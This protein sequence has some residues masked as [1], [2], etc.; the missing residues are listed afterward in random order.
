MSVALYWFRRDLRVDDNPA[1]AQAIAWAQAHDARL[2]PVVCRED[3]A[4]HSPW[5]PLPRSERQRAWFAQA[6]AALR[7][8]LQALNSDLWEVQD[9]AQA[10]ALARAA[11]VSQVFA[12]RI[13]APD[14]VTQE[15][16]WARAWPDACHFI[17]QSTLLAPQDLPFAP[18]D[19]PR[20]FTAFR[21]AVEAAGQRASL[22][23]VAPTAL[24]PPPSITPMS[25][26]EP[27]ATAAPPHDPR[28]SLRGE[29]ASGSDAAWAHWR[30]Y[31]R[32]GL[33]HRYRDT[34]NDLSGHDFSSQLSLDLATGALSPRRAVA[35]LDD[36]EAEH[37]QSKSSY[38]LWFELMWRDHF[39][40]LHWRYPGVS[41]YRARGLAD[42]PRT[43]SASAADWQAW[44]GGQ[45][46]CAL[47]DAGM[48]EL[49][50]TGYLSNRM[51]QI[52]ASHWLHDMGGDWRAGA[53]WFQAQLLDEDVYSN[54]GNWL[55]IAGLGS[56]PRGGR[57]FDVD[58]QAR[59]YDPNGAYRALWGAA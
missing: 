23:L 51:R 44:C 39:R 5:G 36:F 10:H 9:V 45:T 15:K 33:P 1:L 27:P 13:L 42:A 34:R 16:A 52:V 12:E 59:Q 35:L 40:W 55:Y 22:P 24:P 29:R 18:E 54:Q 7:A 57:R 31:L 50:A 47:V 58:K 2:L 28:S 6:R 41:L 19:T 26:A 21:Q 49:A 38:W 3:V 43:A 11:G 8:Q 37:G 4:L 30:D 48:R 46:G 56:D 14:E 25:S 32:R 20:V 53:A 17:W